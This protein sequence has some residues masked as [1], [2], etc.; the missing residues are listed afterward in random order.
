MQLTRS[1]KRPKPASGEP[2]T[3]EQ[4]LTQAQLDRVCNPTP[5]YFRAYVRWFGK[6]SHSPEV[7]STDALKARLYE[8]GPEI[9]RLKRERWRAAQRLTPG[10]WL[11]ADD[12]LATLE[13]QYRAI[14][15][16]L[17]RR[18]RDAARAGTTSPPGSAPSVSTVGMG[19]PPSPLTDDPFGSE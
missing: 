3:F 1:G 6:M 9:A 15:E 7:F 18:A 16:I 4:T 2:A 11:A 17:A 5:T 10:E 19:S 12:R 13:G 8:I 14:D